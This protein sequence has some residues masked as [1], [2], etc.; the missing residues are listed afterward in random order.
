MIHE[1]LHSSRVRSSRV[2]IRRRAASRRPGRELSCQQ[3]SAPLAAAAANG[4][5]AGSERPGPEPPAGG[6][7]SQAIRGCSPPGEA[8]ARPG[9][10]AASAPAARCQPEAGVA[11]RPSQPC[12]QLDSDRVTVSPCPLLCDTSSGSGLSPT[13]HRDCN[14]QL[15]SEP[16]RRHAASLVWDLERHAGHIL[17]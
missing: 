11:A 8:Q 12:Q 7:A 5:E 13:T 10:G 6:P 17:N 2:F 16:R 1:L 9:A 4:R 3:L 14:C 15:D